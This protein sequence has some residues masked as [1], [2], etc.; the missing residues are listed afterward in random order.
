VEVSPKVSIVI[1]VYNGS[2]YLREAIDSALAQTY[3][4]REVIVINDGST[5]E[6]KTEEIARSYGDR[7][8]YFSKENG[9]VASA[10]NKG[11]KEM[12]GDLFSWLSHDDVYMPEKLALQVSHL[13][14][15]PNKVILYGDFDFIDKNAKHLKTERIGNI[16]PRQFRYYLV[17][18]HPIHGC[19]TLIPRECFDNVGMFDETL[20][21]TQD[22]AMWFKL[23]EYYDFIH[24]PDVLI[25]SRFHSEQG[26]LTIPTHHQE[27]NAFFVRCI[28]NLTVDEILTG[29][30]ENSLALGYL[31]IAINL[32]KRGYSAS[33]HALRLAQTHGKANSAISQI[34]MVYFIVYYKLFCSTIFRK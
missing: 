34:K 1:P 15:F 2:N 14:R 17:T 24:T 22:Y 10:L 31:R 18:S 16:E 33:T 27:C 6:G 4:N 7:I 29:T 30:G 9:G 28:N 11:I 21:S 32:R 23:A 8:R 26:F 20:R 13:H 5:D 19:T 3:Q 12:R 25:K